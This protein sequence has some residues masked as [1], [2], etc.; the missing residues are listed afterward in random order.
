MAEPILFCAG[1][2]VKYRA[3][4]YKPSKAYKCPKCGQPLSETSTLGPRPADGSLDTHGKVQRIED[5]SLAG[6]T[7]GQHR[8]VEK[9][10]EGG[11]GA[12]YKAEHLAL[13]RYSVLKILPLYMIEKLPDA[14]ERFTREARAAAALSHPNIV[15][16]YGVGEWEGRR[17]IEMEYVE[18]ET[19]L[20]R[21]MRQSRLEV[22]E[23]TE[24]VR[25]VA[26]ALAAA[27]AK[28]IVHRDIKPANIMITNDG[29][30]KVMDFGLAKEVEAPG[31]DLTTGG[32][33]MGTP[34]YMSPE[35]CDG[36]ELDGRAD[37]YSL[38]TTYYCLLT[39]E[40]PFKGASFISILVMHKT[41]PVPDPLTLRPELP[42][43]V[44]KILEKALAKDRADRYHTCDE[45]VRDLEDVL[46]GETGEHR[47][48]EER[49]AEPPIDEPPVEEPPIEERPVDEPPIDGPPAEESRLDE[50]P[51]EESPFDE[52][53]VEGTWEDEP[54]DEDAEEEEEASSKTD[55]EGEKAPTPARRQFP[56]KSAAFVMVAVLL[57]AAAIAGFGKK[58]WSPDKHTKRL[59]DGGASRGKREGDADT[60]PAAAAP[61]GQAP[62]D[63][64]PVPPRPDV[65]WQMGK[66]PQ[67]FEKAFTAPTRDKDQHGNPVASRDGETRDPQ[68]GWPYEIWLEDPWIEFVLIPA[69]EFTM[70]SPED[71]K[72]RRDYE[73]PVHK[74]QITR[75]FYL[76]KHELTNGQ[77]RRFR[78]GHDSKEYKGDSLNAH[79]QP[80]V[81]VSWHDATAYC[82]WL[83]ERAGAPMR[84]P[85]EAEWEYACR[86][87]AE[88]PYYWGASLDPL[89]CNFGDKNASLDYR[90]A[91]F[92]DGCPVTAKVGRFKPNG[93]G[94]YE[95]L[96][97]VWE[98]CLDGKRP[99]SSDAQTDPR[100]PAEGWRVMRGG[101]WGDYFPSLARCSARLDRRATERGCKCGLRVTVLPPAPTSQASP[102]TTA[103]KT[104]RPKPTPSRAKKRR[105]AVQPPA[106]PEPK[107][108]PQRPKPV[109]KLPPA[110]EKSFM[111]PAGDYDQHGR[112]VA[113]RGGKASD[114]T[115]GFPY[116]IWLQEPRVEFVLIPSGKFMMG[117]PEAEEGRR[118]DEGPVHPV[119][120]AKP[121][122]MGK[123][124]VTNGQYRCFKPNHDSKQY[125]RGSLNRESQ[126]V[127]SLSWHDAMALC[128][129]LG[130]RAD[131]DV[132]LPTEAEWEYAC[133]AGAATRYY[134]GAK[135]DP[136]YCNFAGESV[137]FEREQA[138]SNDRY[139]V[140]APVGRF[141]P[142]AFGLYDT[143]GNVWE[144]CLDGKRS[145]SY[146]PVADPRGPQT[147]QHV[148]RG[149]S[150]F[151]P[152]GSTSAAT[153]YVIEPGYSWFCSG[154][155]ACFA[156][157]P[158]R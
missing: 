140:S 133:R 98:W 13:G 70:G 94:L 60:G 7:I 49:A 46:A 100:G 129:W 1:C 8:I 114:P 52:P 119:R 55:E 38:G 150:W 57:V 81:E 11:M 30:V 112:P 76:G 136:R 123:Y 89:Y 68:T 28:N 62:S 27:H 40:V 48:E 83:E 56:L 75:P 61:S 84:L 141:K 16:V 31:A 14:V 64:A 146:A 154:A 41:N 118:S 78:P 19:L 4:H 130:E 72:G 44:C 10:G 99:Y 50:P 51:V 107:S 82:K 113:S 101:S 71:E 144:W 43:A 18:G 23:A 108:T 12:V 157:G 115:T 106:K 66:M 25:D 85:T 109:C 137:S 21:V 47:H 127:V 121:F 9:L 135:S 63:P 134:W 86:A 125:Q 2:N 59:K 35:Q 88:T 116:E 93:F 128:K 158:T 80:V 95:M 79:N 22:K 6:Q 148:L 33:L 45:L 111:L 32:M 151:D 74:V 143:L 139:T 142:N 138:R 67:G 20:R 15:A 153:R 37:I 91:S 42:P 110:C 17:F 24:I 122:Y 132:R 69:G 147:G 54:P 152:A 58:L 103:R 90:L 102:P 77:Y 26:K 53:P 117:S 124:E 126:P 73:G 104:V 34:S 87:G 105:Q 92:D 96:G 155:R 29:I 3:R 156:L 120:I 145:Y 65:G 39:G 97:N 36:K 149:G 131:V 5:D